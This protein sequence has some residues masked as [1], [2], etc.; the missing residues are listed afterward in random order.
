MRGSYWLGAVG[1][2]EV[3]TTPLALAAA[4]LGGVVVFGHAASTGSVDSTAT[5][6]SGLASCNEENPYLAVTAYVSYRESNRRTVVAVR[7]SFPERW[8][9]DAGTGIGGIVLAREPQTG[10][11]HGL[12]VEP[13]MGLV[14]TSAYFKALTS[15]G[16][17]GPGGIYRITVD[18]HRVE[19]W[20]SIPAGIDPHDLDASGATASTWVGRTSTRS[21]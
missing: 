19:A 3:F 5:T 10:N 14:Y 17:A 16:P 11:V 4:V 7:D 18:P 13:K 12:A 15:F 8:D 6:S 21:H 2:L 1:E 20:L 9:R